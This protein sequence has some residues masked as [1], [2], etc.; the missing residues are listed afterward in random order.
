MR[1][2]QENYVKNIQT[3]DLVF[4]PDINI[5]NDKLFKNVYHINNISINKDLKSD[6]NHKWIDAMKKEYNNL[7]A[8]NTWEL[9]PTEIITYDERRKIVKTMWVL[10]I[11]RDL[12]YK[13]RLVARGDTQPDDTYNE[14]YASTLS[15]ESLRIILSECIQLGFEIEMM[16]ISNAYVNADIDTTIYIQLPPDTPFIDV[17]N[18]DGHKMYGHKLLKSLYGL[19]QSGRN[20]QLLL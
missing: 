6:D 16:D 2:L 3:K 13:A 15:Y 5:E 1:S 9:E 7:L 10:T 11:K 12:S 4:I 19:K 18:Y 20:W 8:H 17:K 14:T